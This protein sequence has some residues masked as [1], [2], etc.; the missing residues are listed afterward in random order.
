[1]EDWTVSTKTAP[2]AETLTEFEL[3]AKVMT[4]IVK[5]LTALSDTRRDRILMSVNAYFGRSA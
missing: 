1:V 5:K 3:D 4:D 2:T